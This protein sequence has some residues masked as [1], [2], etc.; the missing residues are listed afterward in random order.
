MRSMLSQFF[1]IKVLSLCHRVHS[2]AF[3]PAATAVNV[4]AREK[5]NLDALGYYFSIII[6]FCYSNLIEAAAVS[7]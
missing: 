6:I 5:G 2:A 1:V 7:G 4:F 3:V